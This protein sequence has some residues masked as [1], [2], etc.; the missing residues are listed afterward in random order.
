M[1]DEWG[2]FTAWLDAGHNA[3]AVHVVV[4]VAVVTAWYAYLTHRIMRA[5]A[6]QPYAAL[7][8]EDPLCEFARAEEEKFHTIL[9]ENKSVRPVVFL[10]VVISCHPM[11]RESIV[12]KLRGWDDQILSAGDH[13]KLRLDF[14]KEL[15]EL[16]MSED[17]CGFGADIVVSDLSRQVAIQYHFAWVVGLYDCKLG[18]PWNVRWRYRFRPWGWR[19]HRIKGWFSKGKI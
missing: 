1:I 13:A 10:D 14:S 9:V 5:T 4:A 18:M 11:G 8:P 3:A 19:Y 15:A 12:H 6:K 7:Q 16:G 17:M 2:K